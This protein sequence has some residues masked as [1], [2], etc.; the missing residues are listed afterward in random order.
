MRN[1][2]KITYNTNNGD[3]AS[4]PTGCTAALIHMSMHKI[5]RKI[6]VDR[7]TFKK[8]PNNIRM[9]QSISIQALKNTNQLKSRFMEEHSMPGHPTWA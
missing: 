5:L 6:L 4:A 3:L 2:T 7:C 1:I 8:A 9:S